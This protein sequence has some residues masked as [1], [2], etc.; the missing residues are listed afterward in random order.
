MTKPCFNCE[1][2]GVN[3][4]GFSV[5]ESCKS[6]LKLFT[7]ET[8]KKYNSKNPKKFSKEIQERLNFLE[9]GYIKKKIKLLYVLDRLKNIK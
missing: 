8:I 7:D 3:M 6:K 1:K 9:K 2:K 5:C 4:Y